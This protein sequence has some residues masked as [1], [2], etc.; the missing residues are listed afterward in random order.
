MV[1]RFIH[2]D[3]VSHFFGKKRDVKGYENKQDQTTC[4]HI[5]FTKFFTF[6]IFQYC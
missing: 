1:S 5:L 3:E 2:R 6:L 4:Q